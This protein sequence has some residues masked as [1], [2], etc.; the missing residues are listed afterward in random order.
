MGEKKINKIWKSWL[1]LPSLEVQNMLRLR[2][3]DCNW[4]DF[5]SSGHTKNV[6]LVPRSSFRFGDIVQMIDP[7]MNPFN[8]TSEDEDNEFD[9][10]P[11]ARSDEEMKQEKMFNK[12]DFAMYNIIDD[13][14]ERNDLKHQ[15]PDIY[16]Q[17]RKRTLEHLGNIVPE[18]F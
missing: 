3:E 4:E 17:L 7:M 8:I 12:L 11:L 1:P 10:E 16:Q 13:P 6:Q 9:Y 15:F 2:M 5:S 14:E 18:D